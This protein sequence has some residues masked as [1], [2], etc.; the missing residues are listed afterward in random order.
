MMG[1]LEGERLHPILWPWQVRRH[2]LVEVDVAQPIG[3]F[4]EREAKPVAERARKHPFVARWIVGEHGEADSVRAGPRQA[5]GDDRRIK[6]AR[7]T[8]E[9][10]VVS[11]C[12]R[13]DRMLD[14]PGQR[15]SGRIAV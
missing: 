15:L 2:R 1:A 11:G 14:R 13:V 4:D 12:D 8:D 6:S 9:E 5:G 10:T 7:D 3:P